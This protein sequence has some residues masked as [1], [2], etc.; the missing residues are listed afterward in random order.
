MALGDPRRLIELA[1]LE[2][3]RLHVFVAGPGKGEGIAVA[4]P[5]RG[6]MLIDGCRA[7][8]GSSGELPLRAIYQRWCRNADRARDPVVGMV[9]T[10]PH[11]DHADGFAELVEELDPEKAYLADTPKLTCL[12]RQERAWTAKKLGSKAYPELK[13]AANIGAAFSALFRQRARRRVRA[14][15]DG[16]RL[17]TGTAA[18][19]ATVCAPDRP[20]LVEFFA[21]DFANRLATRANDISLVVEIRFGRTRI[22]L[23][24]DLPNRRGDTFVATGWNHVMAGHAE[25]GAHAGLKVPHHGSE[26]AIHD[27]LMTRHSAPPRAWWVTPYNSGMGLPDIG[28]GGVF[29]DLLGRTSAVALTALPAARTHQGLHPPPAVIS[30]EELRRRTIRAKTGNWLVDGAHDVR[31]A[32]SL[33]PLDAV[34]CASFDNAGRVVGQWR[35]DA[36]LQVRST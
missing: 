3:G 33:G 1:A 31:P 6:W 15:C 26:E 28:A 20:G 2:R 27:A 9:L 35:G 32:H 24:G 22:V 4:F 34:W 14:V 8:I 21:G 19:R 23:G 11:Q 30:I 12:R 25:L 7:G 10:H 29:E 5:G 13:Q 16:S 36:A 18:V 17:S